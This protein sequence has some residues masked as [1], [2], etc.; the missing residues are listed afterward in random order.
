MEGCHERLTP[1]G[2]SVVAASAAGAVGGTV[3]AAT[4]GSAVLRPHPEM[5]IRLPTIAKVSR[6]FERFHA[7]VIAGRIL[8]VGP[9][10][11][12]FQCHASVNSR[13][14]KSGSSRFMK[15]GRLFPQLTDATGRPC[16]I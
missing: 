14:R 5:P 8:L 6:P 11:R 7:V 16:R 12:T 4:E 3:S 13:K 15:I 9:A 2:P 10:F 1:N